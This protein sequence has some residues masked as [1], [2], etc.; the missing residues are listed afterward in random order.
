MLQLLAAL[1]AINGGHSQ[2]HGW[3][4]ISSSGSPYARSGLEQ[5]E[6]LCLM[7]LG[8]FVAGWLEAKPEDAPEHLVALRQEWERVAAAKAGDT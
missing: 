4:C 2:V 7:Q 3:G 5:D 6:A 1:I 8:S